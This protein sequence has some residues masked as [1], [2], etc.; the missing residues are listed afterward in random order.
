MANEILGHRLHTLHNL[1]FYL[2]LMRGIRRSILDG[3][4]FILKND[5]NAI[6]F[7]GQEISA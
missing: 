6:V 3:T 5:V 2:G 1:H 4:F 7:K